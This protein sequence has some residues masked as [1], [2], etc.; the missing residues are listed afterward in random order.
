[1]KNKDKDWIYL[2]MKKCIRTRVNL[3]DMIIQKRKFINPQGSTDWYVVG[4]SEVVCDAMEQAMKI[5]MDKN[6][7]D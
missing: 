7:N 3:N 1:M 4:D 6:G 2:P 5:K